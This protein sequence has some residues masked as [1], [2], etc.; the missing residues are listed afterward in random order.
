MTNCFLIKKLYISQIN[1]DRSIW[2][3]FNRPTY[4]IFHKINIGLEVLTEL[5]K[6]KHIS[7]FIIS[8][9]FWQSCNILFKNN[10]LLLESTNDLLELSFTCEVVLLLFY[11]TS[12][13]KNCFS[14][15]HTLYILRIVNNE[16]DPIPTNHRKTSHFPRNQ[17]WFAIL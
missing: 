5:R 9:D 1:L 8:S 16:C 15:K 14:K 6:W 10:F 4:P 2:D 13:L 12:Y 3:L 7:S 17:W 11:K